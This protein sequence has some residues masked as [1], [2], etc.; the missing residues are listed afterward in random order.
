MAIS[1]VH[2]TTMVSTAIAHFYKNIAQNKYHE[3]NGTDE[4]YTE[5][6]GT[7]TCPRVMSIVTGF[8]W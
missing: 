6:E 8:Y 4:Y 3:N 5:K 7:D 2:G 1:P